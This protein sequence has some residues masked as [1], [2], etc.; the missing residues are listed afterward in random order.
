MTEII[1]SESEESQSRDSDHETSE[2]E[3]IQSLDKRLKLQLKK[4]VLSYYKSHLFG[5]IKHKF[6]VSRLRNKYREPVSTIRVQDHDLNSR[7]LDFFYRP[8]HELNSI[9]H[10]ALISPDSIFAKICF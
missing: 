1:P 2:P 5:T 8:R 6:L 9:Q 10:F 4:Q 3:S 7:D